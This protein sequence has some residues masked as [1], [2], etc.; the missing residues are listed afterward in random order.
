M[1]NPKLREFLDQIDRMLLDPEVGGSLADVL[2]ALRGPDDLDGRQRLKEQT[3]IPIRRA[4][5]PRV[6]EIN[7][8]SQV[9]LIFPRTNDT[10]RTRWDTYRPSGQAEGVFLN[11]TRWGHFENHAQDAA[12]ALG[13]PVTKVVSK[14]ETYP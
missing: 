1:I 12:H 11:R 14:E 4:A 10:A 9:P 5:F 6:C 13:L 3:T 2:S 8:P 7:I